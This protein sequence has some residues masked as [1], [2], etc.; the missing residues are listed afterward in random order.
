MILLKV[1]ERWPL[2][3]KLKWMLQLLLL[4]KYELKNN[5]NPKTPSK[6]TTLLLNSKV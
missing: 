1:L 4:T 3:C 5:T 2:K 6:N